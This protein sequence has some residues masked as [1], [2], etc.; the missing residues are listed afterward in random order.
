MSP[1]ERFHVAVQYPEAATTTIQQSL[2]PSPAPDAAA[3]IL[4]PVEAD[5]GATAGN[6]PPQVAHPS[7]LDAHPLPVL[8]SAMVHHHA[9][10]DFVRRA[11]AY[12]RVVSFMSCLQRDGIVGPRT[13]PPAD[14]DVN[15]DK[16]LRHLMETASGTTF[17][18]CCTAIAS[19][20]DAQA[21]ADGRFRVR[22]ITCPLACFVCLSTWTVPVIVEFLR[23]SGLRCSQVH[24]WRGLRVASAAALP[25]IPPANPHFTIMLASAAAAHAIA[26][27]F[28]SSAALAAVAGSPRG[29]T[30]VNAGHRSGNAPIT[31]PSFTSSTTT[32]DTD[33]E[34]AEGPFDR[35]AAALAGSGGEVVLRGAG[36]EVP[37]MLLL[38]RQRHGEG[39]VSS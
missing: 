21:V 33:S 28:E 12:R 17:H 35:A 3:T 1:S 25:D 10:S 32:S 8:P 24:G 15:D 18:W 38:L 39:G 14:V 36:Q 6:T 9:G 13:F 29:K 30:I 7:P 37:R 27:D 23:A 5:A 20:V 26:Q 4:P 31:P 16:Q 34:S 11:A 22:V 19:D 2:H